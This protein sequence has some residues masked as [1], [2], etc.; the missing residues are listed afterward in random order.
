MLVHLSQWPKKYGVGLKEHNADYMN[1]E[2]LLLHNPA[3]I[4]A[5]NVAPQYGTE[6]NTCLPE[7]G[8]SRTTS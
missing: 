5:A 1:D 3:H 4:T 2:T 7:V 6:K 8:S